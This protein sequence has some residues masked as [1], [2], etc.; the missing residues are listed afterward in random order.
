M[1]TPENIGRKL[2]LLV[3]GDEGLD[4]TKAHQ[5]KKAGVLKSVGDGI[6]VGAQHDFGK[7]LDEYGMR[8]TS[9]LFP[10]AVLT[11]RTAYEHKPMDGMIFI[12]GKYHYKRPIADGTA[13]LTIV[14]G[15]TDIPERRD[16]LQHEVI[17]LKDKMG[18]FEMLSSTPELIL[19]QHFEATKVN[20]IKHLGATDLRKLWRKVLH[21]HDDDVKKTY[22]AIEKVAEHA[23]RNAEYKRFVRDIDNIINPGI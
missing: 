13:S 22:K 5:L 21:R 23:G 2:K 16:K 20:N 6:Y 1:N 12:G 7:V 14:Q 17:T 10:N 15:I 4:K 18:E 9:M 3:L 8:L 19:L 11:H